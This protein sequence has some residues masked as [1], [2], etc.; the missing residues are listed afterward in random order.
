MLTLMKRITQAI[1]VEE[2]QWYTA[3]KVIQSGE[4]AGSYLVIVRDR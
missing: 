2:T 1:T 3:H 4:K